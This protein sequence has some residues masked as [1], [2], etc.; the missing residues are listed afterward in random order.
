MPF[1]SRLDLQLQQEIVLSGRTRLT[2]M[3]TAFNLLNQGT[4]TDAW[5]DELSSGQAI[6]IAEVDFFEGVDVQ[7]LVAE[8]ELVRD[9]RFLMNRA[10]QAPRTVRL[11]ARFSF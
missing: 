8:Q 6:D 2:L 3:V 11:A 4:P 10:F 7:Q 1:S 5:T 9:P